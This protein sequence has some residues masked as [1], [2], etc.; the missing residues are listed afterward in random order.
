[1]I[2]PTDINVNERK[3][4]KGEAANKDILEFLESDL[5]V[6]EVV[7]EYKNEASA[8][9]GY[10]KVIRENGYPVKALLRNCTIFLIKTKEEK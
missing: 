6:C 4:S 5:E 2:K 3:R 7:H 1:M 8:L 10:S 9:A